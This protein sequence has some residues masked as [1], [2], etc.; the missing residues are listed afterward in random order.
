MTRLDYLVTGAN[1]QLGRAVQQL[2]AARGRTIVGVG[3]QELAVEDQE[4]VRRCI[5]EHR[6]RFVLHCGAWTNVD[7]CEADPQLADRINGQGTG[8]LAEACVANDCGLVYVSTDFVFDGAANAP[9][10]VDSPV[11]PLSAY[12]RSKR[13]GEVAVLHHECASF[14]V[15]RTSWV[16]G[17]GG[18]NFPKAILDRARSGN[19][20]SVV[21]DQQ[22]RPTYTPDLAAAMLDLCE[23]RAPGGIYHAANEGECNWHEFACEVLR[24]AGLGH[25][26][27]GETTAAKF[28]RPAARPAYSVLDT[29]RLDAALGR[30]FPHY[31]FAVARYLQ[32]ESL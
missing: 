24:Q 21:T 13:L 11:A 23:S 15:L 29:S 26:A 27:V 3:H 1:G 17:P 16:F 14:Y 9:Y 25:I 20:L 10:A 4:A 32:E 7:G 5:G 12:G 28:A 6:P 22:G 18:K 31:R 2:A 8:N 19:P 30:H